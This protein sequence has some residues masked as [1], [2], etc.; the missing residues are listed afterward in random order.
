M[1]RSFQIVKYLRGRCE[2]IKEFPFTKDSDYTTSF[3]KA[4]DYYRY[5]EFPEVINNKGRIS[6]YNVRLFVA[7]TYDFSEPIFRLGKRQKV[8]MI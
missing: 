2:I 5:L 3:G 1:K 6:G 8:T 4:C 7:D